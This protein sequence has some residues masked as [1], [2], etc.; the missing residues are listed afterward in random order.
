[1]PFEEQSDQAEPPPLG[2]DAPH[3]QIPAPG[4]GARLGFLLGVAQSRPASEAAPRSGLP[5]VGVVA[6]G[7]SGSTRKRGRQPPSDGDAHR[8]SKQK[9]G[10]EAAGD[11]QRQKEKSPWYHLSCLLIFLS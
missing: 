8:Q 9:R 10:K 7:G 2:A 5:P 6:G 4:S 3:L 11:A 1:M